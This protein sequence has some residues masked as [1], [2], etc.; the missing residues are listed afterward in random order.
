MLM[1]GRNFSFFFSFFSFS[2]SSLR[3]ISRRKRRRSVS[4]M[5]KPGVG[6]I[7][8]SIVPKT[9]PEPNQ[10]NKIQK[11]AGSESMHH[12]KRKK[13][14]FLSVVVSRLFPSTITQNY[15]HP[16]LYRGIHRAEQTGTSTCIS[17]VTVDATRR[18]MCNPFMGRRE[19]FFTT[20]AFF[21]K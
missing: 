21:K 9:S 12:R 18:S 13:V 3:A 7:G 10:Q 11:A 15:L 2:F 17:S 19:F 6:R 14:F 20:L 5:R 4:R 8:G 16:S 1:E